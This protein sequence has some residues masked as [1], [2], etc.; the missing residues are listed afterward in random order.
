MLQII[1]LR[2]AVE[3]SLN[4]HSPAAA[5][6]RGWGGVGCGCIWGGWQKLSM[7]ILFLDRRYQTSVELQENWLTFMKL[8]DSLK[9]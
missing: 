9:V 3:H 7:F 5:V 8:E 6:L 4:Q 2:G 1:S